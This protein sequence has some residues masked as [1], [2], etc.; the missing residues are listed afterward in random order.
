VPQGLARGKASCVLSLPRD[1]APPRA[2]GQ[3][4][5]RLLWRR[6]AAALLQ[7]VASGF[8]ARL[9][10]NPAS[11]A[12]SQQGSPMHCSGSMPDA[13]PVSGA[14]ARVA[15]ARGAFSGSCSPM[16]DSEQQG[17]W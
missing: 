4:G 10:Q 2:I 9:D 3:A 16:Q 6:A 7:A 17:T 14:K 13:G 12:A 15:C 8:K 5:P 11:S 1:Q